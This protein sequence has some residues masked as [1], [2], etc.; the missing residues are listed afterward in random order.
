ME[1]LIA[2]TLHMTCARAPPRSQG[3]RDPCKG[4]LPCNPCIT[5]STLETILNQDKGRCTILNASSEPRSADPGV[6]SLPKHCGLKYRAMM[7]L[8]LSGNR[9]MAVASTSRAPGPDSVPCVFHRAP[10]PCS[11]ACK[12]QCR[13]CVDPTFTTPSFTPMRSPT[14]RLE[15]GP[16]RCQ[17]SSRLPATRQA[18]RA[19]QESRRAAS[20]L[21]CSCEQWTVQEQQP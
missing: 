7:R 13:A 11:T 4:D 19:E 16:P 9:S 8:C 3:A 12:L 10:S 20:A 17:A 2:C 5:V 21:L 18:I 14:R 6:P 1:R 15:Q